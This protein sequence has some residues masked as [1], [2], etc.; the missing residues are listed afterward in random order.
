[1]FLT[2]MASV[3]TMVLL[4]TG[5][6]YMYSKVGYEG[7]DNK[8]DKV[9]FS[10]EITDLVRTRYANEDEEFTYCL[11]GIKMK[12]DNFLFLNKI[13]NMTILE[14]TS[15]SVRH[16]ACNGLAQIHSHP[17]SDGA[18]F[19]SEKDWETF[20]STKNLLYECVICTGKEIACFNRNKEKVVVLS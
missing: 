20:N 17:G 14:R 13:D 12:G 18:C 19:L 10:N 11:G 4:Q 9:L 7:L 15:V 3:L 6:T 5:V 2:V 16:D 8:D 1:M